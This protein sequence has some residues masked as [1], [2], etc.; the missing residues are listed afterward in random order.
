MSEILETEEESQQICSQLCFLVTYKLINLQVIF[1]KTVHC[2]RI[3]IKQLL[4]SIVRASDVTSEYC[5]MVMT[6]SCQ[7]NAMFIMA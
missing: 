1:L 2:P 5:G 3:L 6:V 7:S 4:E